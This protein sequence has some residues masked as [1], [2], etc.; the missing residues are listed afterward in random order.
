MDALF[1]DKC[2]PKGT[3]YATAY[4]GVAA[5]HS[6][7]LLHRLIVSIFLRRFYCHIHFR[8]HGNLWYHHKS[9][10]GNAV[11]QQLG[12]ESPLLDGMSADYPEVEFLT[13]PSSE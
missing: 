7:F 10:G 11:G 5:T 3:S 2:H 4:H 6:R 1:L 12:E 9:G 8:I 13:A